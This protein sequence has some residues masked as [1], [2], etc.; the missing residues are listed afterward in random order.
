ARLTHCYLA[1]S[2]RK[3]R[4][5]V[6][7]TTTT[8]HRLIFPRHNRPLPLAVSGA[9]LQ[10]AAG[11]WDQPHRTIAIN[12]VSILCE[13]PTATLARALCSV[14]NRRARGW[15]YMGA[16]ERQRQQQ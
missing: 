14:I 11:L 16:G 9:T 8:D 1:R 2:S 5:R 7:M 15:Q 6:L 13:I 4:I 12:C 10:A 3:R